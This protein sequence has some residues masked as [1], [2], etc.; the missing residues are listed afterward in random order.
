[1]ACSFDIFSR[2][3]SHKYLQ[4]SISLNKLSLYTQKYFAANIW[5]AEKKRF[6]TSNSSQYTFR[7][8]TCTDRQRDS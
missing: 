3:I 5:H 1:M 2:F 8:C 6:P 7:S 4:K